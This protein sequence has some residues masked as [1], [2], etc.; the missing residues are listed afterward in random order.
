MSRVISLEYPELWGGIIDIPYPVTENDISMISLELSGSTNEDQIV[1]RN[2]KRYVARLV[3]YNEG[4]LKNLKFNSSSVYLITGGLGFLGLRLARWMIKNGAR[5]LV[6][7]GRKVL[8]DRKTWNSIPKN[9]NIR[10]KIDT[11]QSLEEMGAQIKIYSADVGKRTELSLVFDEVAKL[12]LPL[13]GIFHVAGIPGHTST[14]DLT[15]DEFTSVLHPK[16]LGGWLL[17]QLTK[18]ME[19]D[20]FVCFSSASS[21][22][23]AQGQAHYA[24]ANRFLDNLAHNRTAMGLPSL[25]ID[26]GLVGAGGMVS[27]EYYKWLLQ[28]GMNEIE[29]EQGFEM[30]TRFLNTGLPQAILANIDWKIFKEIYEA[31]RTRP[32]FEKIKTQV[33][34]ID[35]SKEKEKSI[36]LPDFKKLRGEDRKNRIVSY[37]Q[38]SVAQILGYEGTSVLDPQLSLLDLGLDSLMAVELRNQLRTEVRVD[39]TLERFIDGSSIQTLANLLFEKLELKDALDKVSSQNNLSE[40]VEEITF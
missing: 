30:L 31:R 13:R 29:P 33:T 2:E 40:D 19:L 38:K 4:K 24:S 11:I 3:R 35:R 10:K 14:K 36:I 22:W 27:E 26:W 21:I 15:L 37:I 39:V 32:F 9:R 6:L 8:P 18:D 12:G 34:Q 28:I 23:G 17:H 5:H 1:I 20:F 16:V 7:V 25:S